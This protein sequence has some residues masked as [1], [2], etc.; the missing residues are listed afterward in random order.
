[1]GGTQRLTVAFRTMVASMFVRESP[2]DVQLP[3][4]DIS[5]GLY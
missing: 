5:D 2:R 3:R 4:R 1:M